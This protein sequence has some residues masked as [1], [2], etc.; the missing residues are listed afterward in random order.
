MKT[1]D[2]IQRLSYTIGK[3]N[4]PNETDKLAL[5]AIINFVNN[6]DEEVVQENSLFSKLYTFVL[7]EFLFHYK[8]IDFANLKLNKELSAPIEYHIGKLLINLSQIEVNDFFK[9]K[10]ITDPLLKKDNFETYK[11]L[12]PE[13]DLQKFKEV[14]E[15]WDQENVL[16][17]LNRN[18]SESFNTCK[19]V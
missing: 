3:S 19:N 18:I 4:K 16:S 6:A 10:S 17:H 1:K 9:S 8:D 11:H 5:N 12:F 15:T 13:I 2:A 14:C 7:C